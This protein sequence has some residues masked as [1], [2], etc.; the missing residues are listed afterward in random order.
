MRRNGATL[1]T[2]A[3]VCVALLLAAVVCAASLAIM[4]GSRESLDLSQPLPRT[5]AYVVYVRPPKASGPAAGLLGLDATWAAFAQQYGSLL[6]YAGVATADYAADSL[7]PALAA[8]RPPRAP[9][10]MFVDT[11]AGSDPLRVSRYS[12]LLGDPT[13]ATV[14]SLVRFVRENGWGPFD[15]IG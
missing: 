14:A 10:F 15:V 13:R 11:T 3:L 7:P 12:D 9:D 8:Q 1:G 5:Q 6:P 2:H 4:R